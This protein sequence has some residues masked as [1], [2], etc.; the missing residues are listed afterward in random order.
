MVN[1]VDLEPLLSEL[2]AA[3]HH[4][5]VT[6]GAPLCI[7]AGAGAGK[8]RVLTRRIAYRIATE[9]AEAGRVLALTFTRKAAGELGDRLRTLGVHDRMTAGTFHGVA[10]AQLRRY[11][12]D[13]GEPAPALLDSKAR[14]LG[15]LVA[16]RP[17]VATAPLRDL[18]AEIEWAQ[19]RLVGPDGYP[20]AV[21]A[22]GRRP[23]VPAEALAALFARYETEKQRRGLADFDDLLVRCAGALERDPG[24]AAIARWRWRHVFVDEFQD[25]NPL[26]YRLLSA[27]LGACTDLCVVGDP[28][29]AIYGWNGADPQ[30]LSGLPARWPG[31]EVVRL[32]DNHRCTP[33]VVAAAA[34]VLGSPGTGLR[35]ARADGPAPAVRAFATDH[36]EASGVAAEVRRAHD[37]Q[38]LAWSQ[39]AVLVRIN[40]QLTAFESEFRAAQVPYRVARSRPLIDDPE[41]PAG[42]AALD[43]PTSGRDRTDEPGDTVTICTFHRAK[44]LEWQAVW[45]TGLE[46]GLVPISRAATAEAE[47]EERRLLYVALTRAGRELHCS[48]ARQ[49]TLGE[50]PVPRQASRWLRAISSPSAGALDPGGAG[51]VV[52]FREQM[53]AQRD[54]LAGC[55]RPGPF[56]RPP[57]G[58][59]PDPE[60]VESLRCWRAAAARAAGVPA[61]VLF[62]D[63]TLAAVAAA[64]PASAEELLGV[65]G[66][67]PL[68][69]ARYGPVLLDVL[70]RHRASA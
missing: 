37:D 15:R 33:Q 6:D 47:Q 50:R 8:T 30:L 32:D 31:A 3:Q 9:R 4:A 25:V 61:H 36:D 28:N 17:H 10:Y 55:R 66:L 60:I 63:A 48:W 18:A 56:R 49:R 59:E 23:P 11:W 54:R 24:F 26:Q 46:D 20:E 39:M 42:L 7:L 69:V 34:A 38:G 65:P 41:V 52:P 19:A 14:L 64:R 16:G 12:S 1:G 44:G 21:A 57:D 29:Q 53:A 45:V 40:A 2:T 67:G 13:R 68:K 5:V 43:A 70:A 22:A 35:S 62:H 27:W 51:E 58:P